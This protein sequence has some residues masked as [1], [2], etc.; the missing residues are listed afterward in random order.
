[1]KVI[2]FRGESRS[3]TQWARHIGIDTKALIDR[4]G[5]LGWSLEDA[6]TLPKGATR[7]LK[8]KIDFSEKDLCEM[9]R[10]HVEENQ[11]PGKIAPLFGCSISPIVDRLREL[12]VYRPIGTRTWFFNEDYFANIDTP[13]KAYWLGL[14]YADACVSNNYVFSLGFKREDR[15][16]LEQLASDVGYG[17][18]ILD[19]EEDKS[20]N[21]GEIKHY[22]SSR[23][24]LCS[25]KF[26]DH[27]QEKG[28]VQ[29]KT[30]RLAYPDCIGAYHNHFVRGLF[31]GD[32]FISLSDRGH[33]HT[34]VWGICGQRELL[35]AVN[36]VLCGE[37]GIEKKEVYPKEDHCHVIAYCYS[38]S[39]S[40]VRR[41]EEGRLDDFL[42]IRDWLYRDADI[43]FKRKRSKFDQVKQMPLPSGMSTQDAA[44]HIGID[45]R[46][47][48][49]WIHDGHVHAY[50]EG[51]YRRIAIQEAERVKQLWEVGLMPWDKRR[52]HVG[53][54]NC[55]SKL[56]EGQVVDIRRRLAAGENSKEL[57]SYYGVS[58]A[59][60]RNIVRGKTWKGVHEL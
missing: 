19:V 4:L 46:A 49:R 57:A 23:I 9:V 53:S 34:G 15:Y 59:S 12:G 35:C 39:N 42:K 33:R 13:R 41:F 40:G 20:I 2:E 1:M 55:A 18:N 27:L 36:D 22:S 48:R 26:T 58:P 25:K 11:D 50:K 5:K 10:L 31:D 54:N 21:G 45:G 29:N 43:Y 28:V 44:R 56:L 3:L 17:G 24:N 14:F 52:L 30:F 47:L 8:R 16:I 32:G 37:V 38:M 51:M 60:I 7:G 6:L